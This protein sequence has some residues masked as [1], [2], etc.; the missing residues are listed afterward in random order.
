MNSECVSFIILKDISFLHL[1]KKNIFCVATPKSSTTKH[2]LKTYQTDQERKNK[3]K[4]Y[5]IKNKK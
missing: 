5:K 4:N 3:N 1:I 2:T